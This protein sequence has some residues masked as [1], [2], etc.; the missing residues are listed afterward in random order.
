MGIKRRQGIIPIYAITLL[1]FAFSIPVARAQT[2]V[3][4]GA[5]L[6]QT[7]LK[8]KSV[9]NPQVQVWKVPYDNGKD[10]TIYEYVTYSNDKR[11]F[12]LLFVTVVDR[13]PGYQFS[14]ALLSRAMQINNDKV[15]IKFVL[16][17]KH[18]DID[19]Q[20]EVYLPTAT[21][22]SLKR[23]LDNVA[24]EATHEWQEMNSL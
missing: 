9:P 14:Y 6:Q 19:C 1:I 16:D 13:A 8:Y 22:A 15:G 24:W 5:L 18:G 21:P 2:T 23:A 12:A 4:L 11:Q 3:D 7:G 17:G 10:G 20:T